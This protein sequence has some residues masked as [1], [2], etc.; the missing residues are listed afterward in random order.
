MIHAIAHAAFYVAAFYVAAS[1]A[2]VA[3]LAAIGVGLYSTLAPASDGTVYTEMGAV[4]VG[5]D[6]MEVNWAVPAACAVTGLCWALVA[7]ALHAL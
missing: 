5:K 1:F 6:E 2:A 3:L 7:L 4:N